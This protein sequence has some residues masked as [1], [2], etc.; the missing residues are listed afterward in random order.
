[1]PFCTGF[2]AYRAGCV[3]ELLNY[4]IV[5]LPV[6]PGRQSSVVQT[7]VAPV[8]SAVVL[9]AAVFIALV[10]DAAVFIA[11]VDCYSRCFKSI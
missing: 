3:E 8:F 7:E 11:L 2:L 4:S 5:A 1:M 6:S 9:D 10:L